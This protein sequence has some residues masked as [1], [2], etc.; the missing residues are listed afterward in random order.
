MLK[1]RMALP[2]VKVF[3][4]NLVGTNRNDYLFGGD[5]DDYI[6]GGKGNDWLFGGDGNDT[7]DGGKG[8]D[9]LFGGDGNDIINGGDG[10]DWLFG[11][12][13]NNTLNGGNGNDWLFG[14]D[15]NDIINGGAGNDRF[16][17]SQGSD[18]LNGGDG[19]DI[20]DYSFFGEGI[21]LR[22]EYDYAPSSPSSLIYQATPALRV[23]KNGGSGA[24]PIP[25]T[26]SN[27]KDTL[28]SVETIIGAEGQT[29]TINFAFK[30]AG[31]NR[32]AFVPATSAPAITLD[33]AAQTLSYGQTTLTVR[34]FSNAIASP[35]NDT[36]LGDDK[37]NVLDGFI[38]SNVLNGRGGNDILRTFEN[39][40]LTGGDG[41]DQFT[42]KA[43]WK[44]IG[45]R[46][47]VNFQ[48]I[49]A[50]IIT[51]FTPGIDTL[52]VSRSSFSESIPEA[53]ESVLNYFG[54][55]GQG[56]STLAPGRLAPERFLVLGSGNFTTNTLFVY[57]GATGDLFYR[58]AYP[59]LGE[60][61]KVATLQGAPTLT[62]SDI[63]AI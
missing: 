46:T 11:G 15:G 61:V 39:D 30:N 33:L 54:F 2:L 9:Y 21:T 28:E 12:D 48:T 23:V 7:L 24:L 29:N 5:G 18:S 35:N 3:N 43:S 55:S 41:A 42:L 56:T 14:G 13:G 26:A 19:K 27:P 52:A 31:T 38:G 6:D 22:F 50:S 20:A 4:K 8:N 44:V 62:A 45:G 47:G 51:D 1:N 25:L 40:I 60:Q 16:W 59:S 36:L 32:G 58:G 49:T 34:N 57:D 10:N 63:L 53:S 17:G 37:A